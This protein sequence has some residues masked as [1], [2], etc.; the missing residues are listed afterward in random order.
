[1]QGFPKWFNTRQDVENCLGIY[2][3]QMKGKI[4][5]WLKNRF[6]WVTSGEIAS[7]A[8]GIEGDTHRIIEEAPVPGR[9]VYLQQ[10]LQEDPG[11]HL[12]RVGLTVAEAEGM[13]QEGE[14]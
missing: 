12:F 11:A 7:R 2:P 1:M 4:R 5:E 10:E 3:E 13:I 9:I 8:A 6:V 14:T